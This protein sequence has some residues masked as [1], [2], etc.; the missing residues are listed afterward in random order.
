MVRAAGR[1]TEEPSATESC[2]LVFLHSATPRLQLVT[3]S[4]RCDHCDGQSSQLQGF[5]R[6]STE[7]HGNC[8]AAQQTDGTLTLDRYF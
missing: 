7:A 4:F 2:S 3:D 1:S 6:D 5:E 8:S